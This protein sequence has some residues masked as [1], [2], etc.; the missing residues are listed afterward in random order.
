[1]SSKDSHSSDDSP[2]S[3]SE[4][5]AGIDRLSGGKWQWDDSPAPPGESPM[6]RDG[7]AME[8][9]LHNASQVQSQIG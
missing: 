1:M 2:T 8:E 7:T 9:A 5:C 3:K 6:T 4:G